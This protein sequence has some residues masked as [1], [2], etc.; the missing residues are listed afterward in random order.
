MGVLSNITNEYFGDKVREED[1]VFRYSID[2]ENP[3]KHKL[4]SDEES[5]LRALA[6]YTLFLD[7]SLFF[8]IDN[9][10][11]H[12]ELVLSG[13]KPERTELP[14]KSKIEREIAELEKMI[15]DLWDNLQR[16]DVPEDNWG[17]YDLWKRQ[18]EELKSAL[19][20]ADESVKSV[21]SYGSYTHGNGKASGVLLYVDAIEERAKDP[22][23]TM[24]LMGQVMLHEYFHSFYF[25]TGLGS[26]EP[27]SYAEEPMAEFGSLVVL[28]HVASS[29][30]GIAPL[31][32]DALERALKNIKHKQSCTGTTAAYGFGAYLFDNH[33]DDYFK[34]I[35]QYANISCTKDNHGIESLSLKYSL[36]PKYPSSSGGEAVAF[37]KLEDMMKNV[38][39]R[40]SN[41]RCFAT[42]VF[43]YLQRR[44]I[45]NR[46][47][48]Y[49]STPKDGSPFRTLSKD[50]CFCLK[51][52]LCDD[53]TPP[54]IMYSGHFI[55]GESTY[56]LRLNLWGKRDINTNYFERVDDFI[57]MIT[58]IYHGQLD[59]DET[60]LDFVLIDCN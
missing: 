5:F 14:S 16:N 59:I 20:K 27:N 56:Y 34:L 39:V 33:K 12:T 43:R 30:G 7:K 19:N 41:F 2:S 55:I 46:L 45:L 51:N 26:P 9:L 57:N 40:E 25:H 17:L 36:Y 13:E 28:D 3:P 11:R 47:A 8:Q 24:L 1:V 18:L 32:K 21:K 58:Y 37:E 22:Y 4:T 49:I 54:K 50:G 42:G 15:K 29:K 53:S 44:D 6:R 35:A 10:Q 23:D 48:P 60:G 38:V 52:I 31:A